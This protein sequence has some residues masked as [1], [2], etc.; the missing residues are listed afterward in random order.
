MQVVLSFLLFSFVCHWLLFEVLPSMATNDL[1]FEVYLPV[2]E[3]DFY[4]DSVVFDYCLLPV[5]DFNITCL[6]IFFFSLYFPCFV[7]LH[8]RVSVF[9]FLF[10][11]F[12]FWVCVWIFSNFSILS[13]NS[14]KLFFLK[15]SIRIIKPKRNHFGIK[16][17]LSVCCIYLCHLYLRVSGFFFFLLIFSFCVWIFSNFAVSF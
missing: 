16:L 17:Y 15:L 10:L 4:R 8:Q 1:E 7:P 11:F 5:I 14:H 12:F 3:W 6:K 13:F 9:L 2:G